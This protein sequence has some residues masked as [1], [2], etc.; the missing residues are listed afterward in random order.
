M[1]KK[2]WYLQQSTAFAPRLPRGTEDL[3]GGLSAQFQIEHRFNPRH[4]RAK[5]PP[6]ASG[7]AAASM[8]LTSATA[9]SVTWAA[10]RALVRLAAKSDLFGLDGVGQ[11]T[12]MVH[13]PGRH[14]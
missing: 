6:P 2:A 13:V 4:R 9:G 7:P 11:F 10:V 12:G 14:P 8:Q 1:P 3:G 5:P